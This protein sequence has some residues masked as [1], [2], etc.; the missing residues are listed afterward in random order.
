[1]RYPRHVPRELE[2]AVPVSLDQRFSYRITDALADRLAL[3]AR[4]LVPFGPRVLV[5]VALGWGDGSFS[6]G[7]VK[8]VLDVLDP[9]DQPALTEEMLTLCRWVSEYYVAPIGE[10]CRL[11]LPGLL[12]SVD[13][14]VAT[15]SAEGRDYLSSKDAPLLASGVPRP[16]LGRGALRLLEA[17][18]QAGEGGLSVAKLA[19]LRPPVP[20]PL[21]RLAEL[22]T[23]GLAAA[24][25]AEDSKGTARLEA[26]LRAS[27]AVAEGR[28]PETTL[29]DHL[30]RSKKRPIFV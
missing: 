30:G 10:V 12:T 25:W 5:G 11:A 23:A 14:R 16:D 6:H 15:I 2:V 9:P 17:L 1:M 3:G 20:G 18:A 24:T 21:A 7:K 28:V 8:D 27:Q 19:S 22:E 29:R 4:V 26:H 13:G